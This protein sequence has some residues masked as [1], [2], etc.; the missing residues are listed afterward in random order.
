[1]RRIKTDSIRFPVDS[2]E[3]LVYI[4]SCIFNKDAENLYNLL[5]NKGIP[6]VYSNDELG[7]KNDCKTQS[8]GEFLPSDDL[9]D[10]LEFE[11]DCTTQSNCEY[12]DQGLLIYRSMA[13]YSFLMSLDEALE[14]SMALPYGK[15]II[16]SRDY[17]PEAELYSASRIEH[18]Y[19]YP[20]NPDNPKRNNEDVAIMNRIDE[21]LKLLQSSE[22][23]FYDDTNPE[24]R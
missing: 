5:R 12:Q 24:Y 1:M 9:I 10:E 8:N 2:P 23:E 4:F 6:F 19:A 3:H 17:T 7:F 14:W 13:R 11:N 21:L 15:I 18:L 16:E 22:D 20:D